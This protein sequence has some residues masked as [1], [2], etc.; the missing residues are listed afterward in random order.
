LDDLRFRHEC[1]LCL[2]EVGGFD[3][4]VAAGSFGVAYTGP[5]GGFAFVSGDVD[6][7]AF[8]MQGVD[9]FGV[10]AGASVD[11]HV[12]LIGTAHEFHGCDTVGAA[13]VLKEGVQ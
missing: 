4:P 1:S 9:L 12:W 8:A 7:V 13:L 5:G 11:G 3:P 6:P 2:F 10:T